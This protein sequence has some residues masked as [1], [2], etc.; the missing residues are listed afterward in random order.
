M[1]FCAM[2][3]TKSGSFVLRV[4]KIVGITKKRSDGIVYEIVAFMKAC[5]LWDEEAY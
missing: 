2:T 3:D 4:K 1:S 5:N